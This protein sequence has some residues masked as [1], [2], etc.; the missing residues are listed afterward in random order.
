MWR[1]EEVEE[2]G[3]REVGRSGECEMGKKVRGVGGGND[4]GWRGVGGCVSV[5]GGGAGEV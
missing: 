5:R 4:W 3:G 2:G 1:S